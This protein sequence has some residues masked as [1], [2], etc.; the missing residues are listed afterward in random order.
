[1]PCTIA[2]NGGQWIRLV[3]LMNTNAWRGMVE[4]ELVK[5]LSESAKAIARTTE[6]AMLAIAVAPAPQYS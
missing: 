6:G 3:R 5:E 4:H 2:F 1:L